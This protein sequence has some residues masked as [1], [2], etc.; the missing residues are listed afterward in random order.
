[1][2]GPLAQYIKAKEDRRNN[3]G[4]TEKK[5]KRSTCFTGQHQWHSKVKLK[6]THTVSYDGPTMTCKSTAA[7]GSWDVPD[8]V[9]NLKH[10]HLSDLR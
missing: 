3:N 9:I 1:M 5:L 7:S 2:V 8:G 4:A 6:R 10:L